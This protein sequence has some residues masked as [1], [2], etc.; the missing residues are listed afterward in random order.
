MNFFGI[1]AGSQVVELMSGKGYYAELLAARVGPEGKVIAHNNA[2]VLDRFARAPLDARLK[3]VKAEHLSSHQSELDDPKLPP[4]T[5]VVMMVLF[6]H[7]TYWQGVDRA[8]MNRAVFGSL[9]PG[10][11]FGVVDHHAEAGSG[12]RDVENLHRVDVELVKKE[13][14]EAGFVLDAESEILRR[15]EDPRTQNVF[16]M[17]ERGSSDRFVL[18]F[19]KP[20]G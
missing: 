8:A 12:S 5:D 19:K 18:R 6:Y 7:D 3:R 13:I 2:F 10:G 4:E 11:V 14:L 20:G 17:P 15:P 9:K 16:K 1:E